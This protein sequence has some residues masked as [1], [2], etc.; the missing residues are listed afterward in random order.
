M[1]DLGIYHYGARF[2][3]PYLN[4]WLQPDT[5]VPD[6]YN[7]QDWDRYAYAGNNPI[8]YND[9]SGHFR[10]YGFSG[11]VGYCGGGTYDPGYSKETMQEYGNFIK[12]YPENFSEVSIH[13][14]H[15]GKVGYNDFIQNPE[16]AEMHAQENTDLWRNVRLYSQ[17]TPN[18]PLDMNPFFFIEPTPENSGYGIFG[19]I[20]SL[21]AIN[22]L[23]NQLKSTYGLDRAA[24]AAEVQIVQATGQQISG[25]FPRYSTTEYLYRF[26]ASRGGLTNYA[27]YDMSTTRAIYRV[28]MPFVQSNR[29]GHQHFAYWN[30]SERSGIF[31]FNGWFE[32]DPF[33]DIFP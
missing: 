7:S 27:R 10:C 9:P 3:S 18:H 24:L 33:E 19:N 6:P 13:D 17:N 8:L 29:G 30:Y 32:T 5:I 28:D 4:R 15:E 21:A 22:P 12:A 31:N 26:N 14:F 20:L 2:Y 25:D 23:L 11:G 1:L 16:L